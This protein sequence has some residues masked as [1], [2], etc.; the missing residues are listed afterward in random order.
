MA[1]TDFMLVSCT[2]VMPRMLRLRLVDFFVRMWRRKALVRLIPPDPCTRK[3]LAA[4]RLLFILGMAQLRLIASHQVTPQSGALREPGSTCLMRSKRKAFTVAEP[5]AMTSCR[6][7][8]FCCA[9]ARA[10]AA[11]GLPADL[12]S[13]SDPPSASDL[14]S[15]SGLPSPLPSGL[16]DPSG[17]FFTTG[18][19]RGPST[20]TSCRP[21][22]LGYCSTTP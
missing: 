9:V 15:A 1:R 8:Y 7:D 6:D 5:A 4:A 16:P 17:F 12:P 3:R 2:W 22:I 10:G 11:A 21:S 14:P 19:L 20:I 18:T 13:A